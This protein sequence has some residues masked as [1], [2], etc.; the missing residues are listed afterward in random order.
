VNAPRALRPIAAIARADFLE[1]TRRYSFL[2][3][4]FFAVFLGYAAATG[5][6]F[7]QFDEY[8]GVYT[9]GWIGT[10]V[11]MVI[12]CFVSLVGFY[13]V[14]NSVDR[15]RSTGVGQIL[16]AT[17]L[18]K[19][20]YAFG[21]FLSN[22]AVLSSMVA[23]LAVAAL[24]MQFWAAEDP[25][26]HLWA[27]LSPF[28]LLA[29]PAIALTAVS[30]LAFEMLPLLRG[31]FGNVAWF[32]VW[33]FGLS[34]PLLSG[35]RWLDPVGLVVVMDS[36]GKQAARYVPGYRGGMSFQIDIGQHVEVVQAWRW[37]G[38]P[39]NFQSIF[40]RILW[41]AVAC[42]IVPLVALFFDRFD[43]AKSAKSQ[44]RPE[45]NTPAPALEPSATA[46]ASSAGRVHLTPLAAPTS[47]NAFGRLVIAEVRLALQGFRWWW[48]VVALGLLIAQFAA[49]LKISY[50]PLLAFSWFW[51]VLIWSAMGARE[52]RFATSA[53]LFSSARVLPRQL[54][55]CFL[56]GF[57]VAALTGAGTAIRLLLAADARGLLGWLVAAAFIPALAL[58]LGILTGSSK[59]FEGLFVTW[60][61]VG[62]ANHT[63]GLDFT[64]A[65]NGPAT[66]RYALLYLAFTA[67]L[68][69]V[70][71]TARARQLR[72]A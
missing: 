6:I 25:D 26:I 45:K 14:K 13:I 22:F 39:W 57:L 3:A 66:I 20:S 53:L 38:I 31:G 29:L 7:L 47:E 40:L 35:L 32:F 10:L 52:S 62:P 70:A 30:A 68:A 41:F 37:P 27:L 72:H 23:V 11:A 71:F 19:T 61:Y 44:N 58:T 16:A 21:K 15:D 24:V 64:G 69:L 5:K 33:T 51:P 28:L 36:L 17:P 18:S 65:A 48:Y 8:R 63:P 4:L 34:A 42:A 49:P 56:A 43:S 54:P 2:L 46:R 60:W 67:T 12:T 59:F 50:G 9:S 55:A 1:R